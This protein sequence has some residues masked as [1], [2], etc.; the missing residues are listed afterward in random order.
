MNFH[1]EGTLHEI[2]FFVQ[3]GMM[4]LEAINVPTKHSAVLMGQAASPGAQDIYE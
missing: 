2:Q 1:A 4:G 3:N